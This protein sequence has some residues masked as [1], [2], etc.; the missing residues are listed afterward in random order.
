MLDVVCLFIHLKVKRNPKLEKLTKKTL[1]TFDT[2]N[3]YVLRRLRASVSLQKIAHRLC[4]SIT[5]S[6]FYHPST[7]TCQ[8]HSINLCDCSFST[9]HKISVHTFLNCSSKQPGIPMPKLIEF[10]NDVQRDSRLNEI[11]FPSYGE[12]RCMEII[13]RYNYQRK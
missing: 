5:E 2:K 4:L 9:W 13:T 12:K 1:G 10:M 7:I 11:L 6:L 3:Q 8:V